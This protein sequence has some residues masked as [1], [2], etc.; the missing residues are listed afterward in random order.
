MYELIFSLECFS[1]IKVSRILKR[2]FRNKFNSSLS[3]WPKNLNYF[4]IHLIRSSVHLN[5]NAVSSKLKRKIKART[6]IENFNIK[7]FKLM[8]KRFKKLFFFLPL[9]TCFIKATFT[10]FCFD[11]RVT[12]VMEHFI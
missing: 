11:K 3:E 7:H 10:R 12:F 6:K 5:L 8:A 4:F 2:S 1:F 9:S